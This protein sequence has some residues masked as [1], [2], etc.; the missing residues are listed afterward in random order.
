MKRELKYVHVKKSGSN[1]EISVL[2]KTEEDFDYRQLETTSTAEGLIEEIQEAQQ[3]MKA[4]GQL[5][6]EL[7]TSEKEEDQSQA[8]QLPATQQR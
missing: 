8:S 1:T 7:E 6:G 5:S 3:L 2:E 4:C